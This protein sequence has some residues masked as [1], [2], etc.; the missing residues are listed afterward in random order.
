MNKPDTT[1]LS[2]YATP[3][4]AISAPNASVLSQTLGPRV[5]ELYQASGSREQDLPWQAAPQV[6][7][8]G[9][10]AIGELAWMSATLAE[11]M[12]APKAWPGP[13]RSGWDVLWIAEVLQ[14]GQGLPVHD[15]PRADWCACYV[16]DS[17]G[18]SGKSGEIE[19]LDPRGAAV[20]MYAPTLTFDGPGGDVLGISQTVTLTSG[21][22]LVFPAWLRQGTAANSGPR[23]RLAIKLLL[24]ERQDPR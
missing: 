24:T 11:S 4:A 8:P 14:P 19:L 7:Q 23:P 22:L 1:R 2:L 18:G 20:M 9:D 10:A 16:V 12:A 13:S 17:G 3:L 5:M 21:S 6:L 15:Y